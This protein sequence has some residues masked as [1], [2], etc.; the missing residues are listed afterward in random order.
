M[1]I[2]LQVG[3]FDLEF[4]HLGHCM[5]A[6]II[7]VLRL[8]LTFVSSFQPQAIHNML[9]LMLDLHFKKVQLI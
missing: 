8:F 1:F 6:E 9:V 2:E 4:I 5:Q 3:D 7:G